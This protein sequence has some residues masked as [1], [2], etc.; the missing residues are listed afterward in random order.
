M[1]A[2]SASPVPADLPGLIPQIASRQGLKV[3]TRAERTRSTQTLSPLDDSVT[4]L[5][6][7]VV[8]EPDEAGYV[9]RIAL[10]RDWMETENGRIPL[11]PGMAVE[12]EIHTGRRSIISYLLSPL[13]TK[14]QESLHER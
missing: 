3:R 12:V 11:G 2:S 14:M 8:D 7:D 13:A 6:H 4:S 5:S 1:H 9:V 10:D